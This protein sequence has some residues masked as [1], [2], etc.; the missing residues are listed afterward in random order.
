MSRE[1]LL[2]V[3]NIS[4]SFHG[5]AGSKQLILDGISLKINN[6]TKDGNIFSILSLPGSGK[7]ILLK[8][9]SAI[10]KPTGG[11]VLLLGEKYEKP[12]GEIVFIPKNTSSFQWMNVHQNI[13]LALRNK[14]GKN[15]LIEK[16]NDVIS[17]VG[18]AGY[19][20]H[21]PHEKSL[22]F[23]FRISLARALSIDPKV[24]LLD[25]P[26]INLHGESKK[27]IFSLLEFISRNKSIAF[28]FTTSNINEAVSLSNKIFVMSRHPGKI[29]DEVEIDRS[30]NLQNHSEYFISLKHQIEK[31]F[32]R[33]EDIPNL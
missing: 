29:I 19:E 11:E 10:E 4:K 32:A 33:Y 15:G 12:T 16:V 22:G 7:T 21:F 30:Q 28:I 26:L 5:M 17:L 23:R 24:I 9:I 31:S 6:S 1:F 8:I 18:L 3:N 2:E 25:D 14:K 13:E 20:N 27:E